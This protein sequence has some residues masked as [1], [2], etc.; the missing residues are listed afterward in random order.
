MLSRRCDTVIWNRKIYIALYVCRTD[1]APTAN[2][3]EGKEDSDQAIATRTFVFG[4]QLHLAPR[5]PIP[6][7]HYHHLPHPPLHHF[8]G[9]L[10]P[11]YTSISTGTLWRQRMVAIFQSLHHQRNSVLRTISISKFTASC[12]WQSYTVLDCSGGFARGRQ[13]P[14]MGVE[15]S[16]WSQFH[17]KIETDHTN[18]SIRVLRSL[19]ARASWGIRRSRT[20]SG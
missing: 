7:H 1:A 8:P 3:I 4:S 17:K 13:V 2:T 10:N 11:L 14:A 15:C 6:H 9:A 20:A 19:G 16:K 5:A 18:L 12:F